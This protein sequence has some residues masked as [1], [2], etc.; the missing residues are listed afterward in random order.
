MQG[1]DFLDMS[2]SVIHNPLWEESL[3]YRCRPHPGALRHPQKDRT[4]VFFQSGC[5]GSEFAS[6]WMGLHCKKVS[7]VFL[8]ILETEACLSLLD[9]ITLGALEE[10]KSLLI[11][12]I[13]MLMLKLWGRNRWSAFTLELS[14]QFCGIRHANHWQDMLSFFDF[15]CSQHDLK[16]LFLWTC[17]QET[18]RERLI[19]ALTIRSLKKSQR[20]CK[21]EDKRHKQDSARL[22]EQAFQV[23]SGSK[24]EQFTIL[25]KNAH[26]FFQQIRKHL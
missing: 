25:C 24:V 23:L 1:L 9:S 21:R 11:F 12:L 10:F 8:R 26:R 15:L 2:F 18:E 20:A 6:S 19:C 16:N 7:W 14:L 22:R 5:M 13:L 4:V 17:V 3:A